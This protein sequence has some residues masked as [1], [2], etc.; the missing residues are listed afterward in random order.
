M[1]VILGRPHRQHMESILPRNSAHKL[2]DAVHTFFSEPL[3][4]LSAEDD[5]NQIVTKSASHQTKIVA[6][7]TGLKSWATPELQNFPKWN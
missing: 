7:F 1:N 3:S 2:A 5:V 4:F 6:A